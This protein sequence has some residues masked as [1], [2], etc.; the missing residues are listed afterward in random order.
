[1]G[2]PKTSVTF[3]VAV[4]EPVNFCVFEIPQVPFAFES[5]RQN[6]NSVTKQL[7]LSVVY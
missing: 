3:S 7:K 6:D 1:M 5:E 4:S 2:I